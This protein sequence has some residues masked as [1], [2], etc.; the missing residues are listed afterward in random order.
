L[1][2]AALDVADERK[3]SLKARTRG[4]VTSFAKPHKAKNVAMRRKG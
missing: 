2:E 3:M 4:W 1:H